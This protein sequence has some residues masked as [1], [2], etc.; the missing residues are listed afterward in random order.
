MVTIDVCGKTPSQGSGYME[1]R[2]KMCILN[3]NISVLFFVDTTSILKSVFPTSCFCLDGHLGGCV[4]AIIAAAVVFFV[5]FF[6]VFVIYLF[7]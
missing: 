3:F 4:V 2:E 6:Y 7:V 5:Y 1:L